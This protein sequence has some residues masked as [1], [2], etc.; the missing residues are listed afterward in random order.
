MKILPNGNVMGYL[1]YSLQI[2]VQNQIC[3]TFLSYSFFFF[4]TFY[5]CSYRQK[6]PATVLLCTCVVLST[7]NSRW[8]HSL[9]PRFQSHNSL[10]VKFSMRLSC[11]LIQNLCFDRAF[12]ARR[13]IRNSFGSHSFQLNP[14]FHCFQASLSNF[15]PPLIA[16]AFQHSPN[17]Q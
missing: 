15:I 16:H 6:L 8:S 11:N 2:V 10:G 9:F 17:S 1:Y 12:W 14:L 4:F 13:V 5:L 3:F 7:F